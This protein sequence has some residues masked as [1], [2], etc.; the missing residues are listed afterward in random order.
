MVESKSKVKSFVISKKV[1]LEAWE[2]VKSNQGAGGV[3]GET[4]EDFERN[5]SGNLYQIW[6]VCN[7]CRE[8]VSCR[9]L[10]GSRQCSMSDGGWLA[11]RDR[12]MGDGLKPPRAA[13]AEDRCGERRGKGVLE[14]S[15]RDRGDDC[16]LRCRDL[17][18]GIGTGLRSSARDGVW[19]VPMYWP[20]GVRHRGGVNP[21]CG[22]HRERWKAG[23]DMSSV[24]LAGVIGSPPGGRYREG[25]STVAAR[26]G[27]PS[28]SSCEALV[29][30]VEPRGWLVQGWFR[31]TTGLWSGGAR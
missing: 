28:R 6:N 21:V 1:V 31:W 16:R 7:E 27:G 14:A 11:L 12:P 5:L 8:K 23:A 26:A 3:D 25:L 24:W 17:K 9:W 30:G 29:M 4:I 2:D 13:L 18:N 15:G 10:A 20:G 22:S 19:R